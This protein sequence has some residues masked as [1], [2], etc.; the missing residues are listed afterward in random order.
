MAAKA[1]KVK[2]RKQRDWA[3]L[4]GLQ[5]GNVHRAQTFANRKAKANREAC[6]TRSW[7]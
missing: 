3:Y 4:Q 5:D 7:K 1:P 6:K 2:V